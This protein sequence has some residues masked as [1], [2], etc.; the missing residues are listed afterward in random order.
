VRLRSQ[1]GLAVRE[2]PPA[3]LVIASPRDP[4]LAAGFR[5]CDLPATDAVEDTLAQT[6]EAIGW[7]HDVLSPID[8]DLDGVRMLVVSLCCREARVSSLNAGSTG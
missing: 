2:V 7:G 5:D 3:E 6:C 8:F 4:G 1:A